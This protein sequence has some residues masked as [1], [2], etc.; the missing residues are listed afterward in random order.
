MEKSFTCDA[1]S[2]ELIFNGLKGDIIDYVISSYKVNV[3]LIYLY[4]Y[5]PN[6]QVHCHEVLEGTSTGKETFIYEHKDKFQKGGKYHAKFILITTTEVC[7]FIVMTTNI[8]NITIQ[9]CLNDYYVITVPKCGLKAP[10]VFTTRLYQFL[11]AYSIRLKSC[12]NQY[13]WY[14]LEANL[15][16]SIPQGINHSMCWRML[17]NTNKKVQGSA[18]IR[19]SSLALGWDIKKILRI[20]QCTVEYA[21]DYTKRPELQ[22]LILYNFDNNLDKKTNKNKYDLRSVE[23]KPF[24]Y[25]RYTI[26]Y[27]KP[28]KRWLIITSANLGKSAWGTLKWP[29][30][31]AELGIT[32]N[33]KF[34]FN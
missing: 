9:N 1:L 18:V 34:N 26:E 14:G 15:L 10:N 4:F 29:S 20:Q 21:K 30:L 7:R 5:H 24:H 16:V 6:L 2:R 11:D 19:T 3:K 32:W 12:L 23:M 13:D 27:T 33:S 31:N 25:K 28:N 17:M 22:D 8:T